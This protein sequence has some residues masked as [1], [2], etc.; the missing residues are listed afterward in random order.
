M[1]KPPLELAMSMGLLSADL[2]LNYDDGTDVAI[3]AIKSEF[4][5]R[6]FPGVDAM[7]VTSESLPV[8]GMNQPLRP[9]WLVRDR[10]RSRDV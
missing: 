7:L 1:R 9:I 2:A 8:H 3:E 4:P 6:T 5:T 10:W